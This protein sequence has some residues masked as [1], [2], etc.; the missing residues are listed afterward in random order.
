MAQNDK[1]YKKGIAKEPKI[2]S[3]PTNGI[4]LYSSRNLD[5]HGNKLRAH[6]LELNK[7]KG[8]III[9]YL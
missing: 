5:D 6:M 9:F 7:I 1:Q 3:L 2:G 8:L 4:K